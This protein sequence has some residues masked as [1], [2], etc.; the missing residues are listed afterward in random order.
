MSWLNNTLSFTSNV[1]TFG[2][3]SKVKTAKQEYDLVFEQ[4]D[5]LF[6]KADAIKTQTES[7]LNQVGVR[8]K[9]INIILSQ[10]Q[11]TLDRE[12]KGNPPIN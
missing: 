3:S 4:Y 8:I 11:T 12:C 9:S 10:V 2:G 6:K 5:P 1:F 7:V